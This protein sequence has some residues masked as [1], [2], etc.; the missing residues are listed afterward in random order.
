M[1]RHAAV[2]P[3]APRLIDEATAAAY[4]GRGRTK[5][6]EQ[7]GQGTLPAP[8]DRNGNVDLWDVRI[9]DQYVDARSGLASSLKGWDG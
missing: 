9:L 6:R 3:I 1:G 8:S 5:F 7:V 2:L 4:L